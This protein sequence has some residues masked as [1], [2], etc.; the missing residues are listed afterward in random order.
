M[1]ECNKCG[2][3]KPLSEFWKRYGEPANRCKQCTR[4]TVRE[5]RSDRNTERSPRKWTD[6]E[7]DDLIRRFQAGEP[8]LSI[9]SSLDRSY[10]SCL[11]KLESSGIRSEYRHSIGRV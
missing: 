6:E 1:K 11:K 8:I 9:A 2:V 3:T 10:L 5:W 7:R 4:E